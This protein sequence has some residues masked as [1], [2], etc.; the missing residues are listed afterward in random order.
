MSEKDYSAF[1]YCDGCG[2]LL[3]KAE[4]RHYDNTAEMCCSGYECGCQGLP[5]YPPLCFECTVPQLYKAYEKAEAEVERLRKM[6]IDNMGYIYGDSDDFPDWVKDH[7]L[8]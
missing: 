7:F 3:T 1:D 4:K 6:V 2:A 8:R 5:L